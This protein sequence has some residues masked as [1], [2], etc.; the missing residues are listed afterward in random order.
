MSLFCVIYSTIIQLINF[1][2]TFD[3]MIERI[4]G[5]K[6]KN[7]LFLGKAIILIGPR[8]VGKSTLIRSILGETP[9]LFL[10]GD[11]Q[12][13]IDM[14]SSA[15]TEQLKN[16]IGNHKLLFIDEIQRIP[17]IGLKLKIIIDQIKDVQIIC[18]GS[19]A[20]EINNSIQEPLTG[21]KF[22]YN[23]F[24]ISW[25]EYDQHFGYVKAQQNLEMRLIYGMYPDVINNSG[26]EY[27]I[28]K[29]LVSSYLYKDILNLAGIRKP[30]QLSKLLKALAFQIGSEVSYNELAQTVGIDK[31]TVGNYLDLLEKS[32]VIFRINS[33]SKNLR[34]EIKSNRK[35]YFYD[36]GL[37]NMI[38]GNF[39]SLE[40]RYD[41]G[42]IWENFLIAE[43]MK[44]LHYNQSL[45]QSYF[46]RTTE[47]QEI[48]YIEIIADQTYAYEFKWVAKKKQRIPKVFTESYNPKFEV[49]DKENFRS[50]LM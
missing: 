29:N 44:Y 45:A 27:E 9:Y 32:F 35:I 39:D 21:R 47:Q 26:N 20:I 3:G 46:W 16:I 23:L 4:L 14:I 11:D 42:A 18:S 50:F 36:T 31:N 15:N 19:S 10:D 48:D 17:Q 38:I 33:Y 7:K 37:R 8:Q 2:N 43:R 12:S 6:I 30:E 1:T 22:E 13:I 28:L 34:N 41:K 49:I 25:R 24:P 5:E 40:S